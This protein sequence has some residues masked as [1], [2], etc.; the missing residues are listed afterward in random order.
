MNLEEAKTD[1]IEGPK[2]SE[3]LVLAAVASLNASSAT[4][5]MEAENLLLSAAKARVRSMQAK[6]PNREELLQRKAEL[7]ESLDA[8]FQEP[9]QLQETET[10]ESACSVS[11]A[12]LTTSIQEVYE[13]LFFTDLEDKIANAKKGKKIYVRQRS[14]AESMDYVLQQE[15]ALME[16]PGVFFDEDVLQEEKVD[17][18]KEKYQI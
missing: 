14:L 9:E 7:L 10:F 16:S 4:K 15:K 3:L 2:S 13:N 18:E 1:S 8:F 12:C 11:P 17:W 6:G 5:K